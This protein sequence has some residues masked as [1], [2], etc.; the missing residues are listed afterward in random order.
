MLVIMLSFLDGLLCTY[1]DMLICDFIVNRYHLVVTLVHVN[2]HFLLFFE[3]DIF[4]FEIY[5]GE[6][7]KSQPFNQTCRDYFCRSKT[8]LAHAKKSRKWRLRAKQPF[9]TPIS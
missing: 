9:H 8:S 2:D 4:Y 5:R 7:S 1:S 6:G 3:E